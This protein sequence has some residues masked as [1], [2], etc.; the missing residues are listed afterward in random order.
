MVRRLVLACRA[1]ACYQ[2]VLTNNTLSF[3]MIPIVRTEFFARYYYFG[4]PGF[5]LRVARTFCRYATSKPLPVAH[6]F[7]LPY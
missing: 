2:Y 3:G 7:L 6:L 5:H 4:D 1:L